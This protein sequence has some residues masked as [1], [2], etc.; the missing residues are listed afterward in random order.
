MSLLF[1]THLE[2]GEGRK[3]QGL[4][5]VVGPW[6]FL[7][8]HSVLF[9]IR[10]LVWV[11]GYLGLLVPFGSSVS[12]VKCTPHFRWLASKPTL[13]IQPTHLSSRSGV[14]RRSPGE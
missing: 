13:R 6:H 12:I 3:N 14:F 5:G 9:Q 4:S 8:F 2:A 7:I 11:R 1:W 10:E